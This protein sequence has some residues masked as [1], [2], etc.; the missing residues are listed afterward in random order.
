MVSGEAGML[1][2]ERRRRASVVLPDEEGPERPTIRFLLVLLG[3]LVRCWLVILC[4]VQ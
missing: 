4:C 2:T 1:K 3:P